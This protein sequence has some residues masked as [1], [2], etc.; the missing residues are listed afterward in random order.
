LIGLSN[1]LYCDLSIFGDYGNSNNSNTN[2]NK[3]TKAMIE[4][5]LALSQC[6]ITFIHSEIIDIEQPSFTS[7]QYVI[8]YQINGIAS[9]HLSTTMLLPLSSNN[10]N[11]DDDDN[12][13]NDSTI[14]SASEVK[15]LEIVFKYGSTLHT[16]YPPPTSTT[17]YDSNSNNNN[18]NNKAGEVDVVIQRPILYSAYASL[19]KKYGDDVDDDEE[20]KKMTRQRRRQ[21]Q[22]VDYLFCN[23]KAATSTTPT[24]M[25]YPRDSFPLV[26]SIAAGMD[27]HYWLV[28]IVSMTLAFIGGLLVL[29]SLDSISIW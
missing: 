1:G 22:Q 12:N 9:F 19:V 27:D 23:M 13:N 10:N 18:N 4:Q 8:A 15:T 24:T 20:K 5:K 21:R 7:R 28:T 25:L 16:R 29:R 17:I 3:T 2:S 14:S 26:I 6:N 11:N